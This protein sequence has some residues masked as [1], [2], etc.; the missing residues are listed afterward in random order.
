MGAFPHPHELQSL[1]HC[2]LQQGA[3]QPEKSHA[4]VGTHQAEGPG[5]SLATLHVP[6]RDERAHTTGAALEKSEVAEKQQ[7]H[8]QAQRQEQWPGKEKQNAREKHSAKPSPVF[9]S[10]CENKK[11]KNQT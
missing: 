5:H 2:W 11:K 7:V 10:L 8:A 1:P 6:G 4:G 3:P 9:F